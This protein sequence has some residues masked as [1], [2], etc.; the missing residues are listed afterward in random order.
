[1]NLQLLVGN[2]LG[3][4]LVPK[5]SFFE[6]II[7]IFLDLLFIFITLFLI[8]FIYAILNACEV[9]KSIPSWKGVADILGAVCGFMGKAVGFV[10][11]LF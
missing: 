7:I 6:I 3:S 8:V 9:A 4:K 5:L 2:L 1:M 11:S 10:K